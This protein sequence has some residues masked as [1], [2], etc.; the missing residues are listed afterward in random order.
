[1]AIKNRRTFFRKRQ[2]NWPY[3]SILSF[4]SPYSRANSH[5]YTVPPVPY[6]PPILF[7]SGQHWGYNRPPMMP[8][9]PNYGMTALGTQPHVPSQ[10]LHEQIFQNPLQPDDEWTYSY[11]PMDGP[12]YANP[13]PIG[14]FVKPPPSGFQSVLKSFKSQDGTFDLNKVMNTTGQMMNAVSQFSSLVK[15]FGSIFKT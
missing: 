7:P 14:G 1:M 2:R 8:N 5:Y 4:T 6:S 3:P 11:E 15:G 12:Q 10:P 13:Y 9:I